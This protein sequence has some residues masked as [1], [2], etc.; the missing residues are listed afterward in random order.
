MTDKIKPAPDWF[1]LLWEANRNRVPMLLRN[2][3]GKQLARAALEAAIQGSATLATTPNGIRA[4]VAFARISAI[5]KGSVEVCSAPDPTPE[6]IA[7]A[8]ERLVQ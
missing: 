8:V 6:Q 1:D 7:D 3:H 2:E 5:I 4:L